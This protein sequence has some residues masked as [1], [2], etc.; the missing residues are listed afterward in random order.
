MEKRTTV[1]VAHSDA[2]LGKPGEYTREQLETVKQMIREVADQ[3]M[4]GMQKI[5]K[6]GR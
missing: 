5:V 4:G 6:K 3:T 1:A 2:Y